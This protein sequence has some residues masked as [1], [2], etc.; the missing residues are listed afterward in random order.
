VSNKLRKLEFLP[1]LCTDKQDPHV[2]VFYRVNLKTPLE[3]KRETFSF[4]YVDNFDP[5]IMDHVPFRFTSLN[6][7]SVSR[8]DKIHSDLDYPIYHVTAKLVDYPMAQSSADTSSAENVAARGSVVVRLTVTRKRE[9]RRW[10]PASV[11][12]VL[13]L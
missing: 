1:P 11:R 9:G 5:V 8:G 3:T 4:S 2:F 6:Y 12:N 7:F 10:L 13:L